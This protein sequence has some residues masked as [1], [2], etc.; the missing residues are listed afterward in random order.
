MATLAKFVLGG[1]ALYGVIV[2]MLVLFQSRIIYPAPQVRHDPPSGFSAVELQTADGLTLI[3]HW[4]PPTVN[5]PVLVWF[6]GNGGSLQGAAFETQLLTGQGYGVLL[7][8]YRGYDGEEGTP[9]EK[10]LYRD[11]R[12]AMAFVSDQRVPADRIIIGGNSLGSGV[13][14]QMGVE[15]SPAA[16]VLVSPFSSLT[17]VAA[18]KLAI[19]PVRQLLRD[20]YDNGAK[21]AEIKSP[22][23]ILHGTADRVIDISF[24]RKLVASNAGAELKTFDGAGH[25]LSFQRAAQAAQSEWLIAQGL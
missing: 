8:P 4:K 11:G 14:V 12:A 13:A 17:D 10:G 18:R 9:S 2:V 22:I 20:R 7:A 6:H 5:R 16:M 1:A 24:A 23:L 25:D 19:V 15:H 3:A 21:L